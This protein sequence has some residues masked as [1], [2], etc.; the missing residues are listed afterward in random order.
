MQTTFVMSIARVGNEERNDRTNEVWW[1]SAQQGDCTSTQLKTLN[2]GRV[3][4]VKSVS[5]MVGAKDQ[6][7]WNTSVDALLY[8]EDT[9]AECKC[10]LQKSIRESQ[11]SLV[12]VRT[13]QNG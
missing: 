1:S 12:S 4:I 8:V 11:S 2:N 10:Y 13:S 3:E 5:R 7:L 9:F 6:S